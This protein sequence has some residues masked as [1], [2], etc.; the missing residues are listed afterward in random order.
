MSDL[1]GY[2]AEQSKAARTA[3]AA[4][5]D[6]LVADGKDIREIDIHALDVNSGRDCVIGQL[7][8]SFD[9]GQRALTWDRPVCN[10]GFD[11]GWSNDVYLDGGLL[12]AAWTE[13]IGEAVPF[14]VQEV[15]ARRVAADADKLRHKVTAHL[16]RLSDID[17]AIE[18]LETERAD[19]NAKVDDDNARIGQL[20]KLGPLIAAIEL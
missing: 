14:T 16:S 8:G 3:V 1:S 15:Y 2:N 10:Y 19:L 9:K 13:R 18:R 5:H 6:L 11:T 12:R 7:Y 17:Q 4:G 20:D